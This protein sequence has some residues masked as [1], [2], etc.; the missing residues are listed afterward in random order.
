MYNTRTQF[1]L[2][3]FYFNPILHSPLCTYFEYCSIPSS[4][5]PI[6]ICVENIAL[7]ICTQ[8]ACFYE[9]EDL[10]PS[11]DVLR[12][13]PHRALTGAVEHD[14]LRT[15][16]NRALTRDLYFST[17]MLF[18][19]KASCIASMCCVGRADAGTFI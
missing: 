13:C 14:V 12:T 1:H 15:C 8:H 18:L 19:N 4:P 11:Q 2:Q 6:G 10:V 3:S 9:G 7:L 17:T 16:P 5:Q